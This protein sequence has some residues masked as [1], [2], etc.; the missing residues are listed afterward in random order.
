MDAFGLVWLAIIALGVVIMVGIVLGSRGRG[1]SQGRRRPTT[2]SS[3]TDAALLGGIAASTMLPGDG[4]SAGDGSGDGASAG[5]SDGTAS[6]GS[7]DGGG[8]GSS[9][10]G[11][12]GGGD[13]TGT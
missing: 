2:E 10:G 5:V 1:G 3:A 12:G 13:G 9:S 4:A 8:G 7:W 6:G 11:D